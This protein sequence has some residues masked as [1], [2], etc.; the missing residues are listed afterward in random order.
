[1]FVGWDVLVG[2]VGRRKVMLYIGYVVLIRGFYL[3]DYG[4]AGLDG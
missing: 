2:V 1:M 3:V 4:E